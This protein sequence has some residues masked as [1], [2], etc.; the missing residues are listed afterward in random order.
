MREGTL[1]CVTDGSYMKKKAPNVYSTG[2]IMACRRTKRQIDGILTKISPA[3]SYRG[4]MLGILAICLFLL[5][6]EEFYGEVTTS[7][8]IYC[9]NK[10]VLYTFEGNCSKYPP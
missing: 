6:I 8:N 1:V 5:A 9:N 7:N 4:E 10:G 3:D 2:W